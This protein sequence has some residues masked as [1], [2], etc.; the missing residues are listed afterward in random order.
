[1]W[2]IERVEVTDNSGDPGNPKLLNVTMREST[3]GQ[4]AVEH[5][6][7]GAHDTESVEALHTIFCS[8]LNG[9]YTPNDLDC[10]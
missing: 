8:N 7:C 9:P 5:I 1:M 2:R 3:T 4:V 10:A 6:P